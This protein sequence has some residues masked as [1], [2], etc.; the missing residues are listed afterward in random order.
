MTNPATNV[1]L[2]NYALTAGSPAINYITPANSSTT[3]AA[4]EPRLLQ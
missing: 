1:T 4:A 2:A 3:Y